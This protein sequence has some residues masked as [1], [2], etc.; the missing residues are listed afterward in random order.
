MAPPNTNLNPNF[1][2][3]AVDARP[4]SSSRASF[5]RRTSLPA[6]ARRLSLSLV[7]TPAKAFDKVER[8]VRQFKEIV[9]AKRQ[10][11]SDQAAKLRKQSSASIRQPHLPTTEQPRRQEVRR[12]SENR[13]RVSEPYSAR[14]PRILSPPHFLGKG[15]Y[16]N[17][18]TRPTGKSGKDVDVFKSHTVMREASGQF[19]YPVPCEPIR[20]SLSSSSSRL[21]PRS[22]EARTRPSSRNRSL[23]SV[24][25]PV[26]P[27]FRF[28]PLLSPSEEFKTRE[29]YRPLCV[30]P[31]NARRPGLIKASVG[32]RPRTAQGTLES[33]V[34]R[35]RKR[36]GS[37]STCSDDWRDEILSAYE[38][39]EEQTNSPSLDQLY[40]F[41]S[42]ASV[43]DSPQWRLSSAS[44]DS[45]KRSETGTTA[46]L[47]YSH[48]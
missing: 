42:P 5:T 40:I 44:G 32:I 41:D 19:T 8:N 27:P 18:P 26:I 33:R 31:S 4:K 25:P 21:R 28:R 30:Q 23:E 2:F 36:S 9:D 7:A 11:T 46:D 1:I 10:S 37:L 29:G 14:Q 6:V 20:T 16:A 17:L 12:G 39:S 34:S 35:G 43:G 15:L 38:E 13:G 24:Q 22:N 47:Y 45:K 48:A 3:S